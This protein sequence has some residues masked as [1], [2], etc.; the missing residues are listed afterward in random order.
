MSE[1]KAKR[2]WESVDTE[3]SGGGYSV[4]L[5]GR[6][7][8]TPLRAPLLLPTQAMADAVA[9]EWQGQVETVDPLSMPGTRSANAA[10][11]KVTVQHGEVAA[12]LAAYA[13]T[14]LLCHRAT[15]PEGLIEQQKKAWDPVLAW[16]EQTYGV[17]LTVTSGVLPALHP[18][19]SLTVYSEIVSGYRPFSLTALHDLVGL[20]GS[21]LLGLYVANALADPE[22]V[23]RLSRIDEDWQISQW[24]EDEEAVAEAKIKRGSFLHAARFLTLAGGA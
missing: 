20:S 1:W 5:D 7:V 13:E 21:L 16:A 10:I 8:R 17:P 2:F 15:Y 12:M 6:S 18:S 14:D 11:D 19:D 4:L 22:V 24:G 9:E 23:W 3:A